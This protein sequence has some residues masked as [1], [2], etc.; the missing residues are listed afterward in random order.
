MEEGKEEETF[1]T[2]SL[3]KGTL[4]PRPFPAQDRAIGYAIAA[5]IFDFT[6]NWIPAI[7][8]G[9]MVQP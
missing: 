3:I 7:V 5:E 4:F 9:H 2:F 8:K 6:K 1:V